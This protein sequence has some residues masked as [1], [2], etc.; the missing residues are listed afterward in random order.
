MSRW[1]RW[2]LIAALAWAAVLA[3]CV[4]PPPGGPSTDG[5]ALVETKCVFCHGLDLV[6]SSTFD[7]SGWTGAVLRMEGHGLVLTP[8]QERAIVDYLSAR[9]SRSNG[10]AP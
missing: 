8:S 10:Y 5:F 6:R 9:S 7:R 4:G 2:L 1:S 3:G